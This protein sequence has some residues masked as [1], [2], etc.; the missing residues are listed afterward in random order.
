MLFKDLDNEDVSD[1]VQIKLQRHGLF[2][3]T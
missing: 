2:C 1:S 3:W